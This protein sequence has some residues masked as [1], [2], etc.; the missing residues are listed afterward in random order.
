MTLAL[1]SSRLDVGARWRGL[2]SLAAMVLAWQLVASLA[3][4]RLFPAPLE[5]SQL[6]WEEALHGVLFHHL[7]ITLARVGFSLAI[8]LIVGS[9][10]GYVAGRWSGV[11]LWL[12]PW[13]L[14]SLNIPA[15]ITVIL[16][17]VW[18]GLTEVALVVAVA[19]N[20][21]PTIAVTIREGANRLDRDLSEMAALY[22]FD[23]KVRAR[24]LVLPQL[25]PYALVAVRNGLAL[26]WKI[27]LVAELLGRSD[28]VGFQLQVFFQNFDVA[29]ILVYTIAFTGTVLILEYGILARIEKRC[30]SWRR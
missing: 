24:H 13:V 28:G 7:G 22:S 18:L 15:L 11:D 17:Y 16:V 14:V 26:T 8:A 12:K 30:T 5:V 10:I 23:W 4:S 2:A 29:H 21:I 25:A 9:A 19:L 3:G 20:K 1:L 6:L 27:V